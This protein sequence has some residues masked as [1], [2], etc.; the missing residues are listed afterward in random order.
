MAYVEV[1]HS[2]TLR[3]LVERAAP[4]YD[5]VAIREHSKN[6][7]LFQSRSEYLL[8]TGDMIWIP[9]EPPELR[10]FS[11]TAGTSKMFVHRKGKRGFKILLRYP[12]GREVKNKP[13]TLSVEDETVEGTTDS[14]GILDA[15][16]PFSATRAEVAVDGYIKKLEIGALEPLHVAKGYQGRLRNLG[17]AVGPVDGKVGP[18]TRAAIRAFQKDEALQESA[19]MNDETL[20]ALGVRYG[21]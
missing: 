1:L 14:E 9:D 7:P 11:I 16:V 15:E 8:K 2:E 20:R 5:H 3:E 4:G 6:A 18:R 10:W 13:Y 19:R 17:Y 12:D 21:C